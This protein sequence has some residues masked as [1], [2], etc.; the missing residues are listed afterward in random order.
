MKKHVLFQVKEHQGHPA[1]AEL[2]PFTPKE[3]REL[4]NRDIEQ[5]LISRCSGG[6]F[7]WVES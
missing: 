5:L 4:L 6:L 2:T 1:I 3:R 7:G